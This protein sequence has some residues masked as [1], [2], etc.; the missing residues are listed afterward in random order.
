MNTNDQTYYAALGT[1]IDSVML[2]CDSDL[3]TITESAR[4]KLNADLRGIT[5]PVQYE[6][7][8]TKRNK[9]ARKMFLA[10]V[11]ALVILA[12]CAQSASAF[13]ARFR[14]YRPELN[15]VVYPV[16]NWQTGN[17]AVIDNVAYFDADKTPFR[18]YGDCALTID[19]IYFTH[20][21]E[22][23]IT[24]EY[25]QCGEYALFMAYDHLGRIVEF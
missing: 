11:M 1:Y 7:L 10:L 23:R 25:W 2:A 15:Q 16:S 17:E 21:P 9:K 22:Y 13:G 4:K 12:Y 3:P 14:F 8:A 6:N 24:V 19:G 20:A 18:V 5:I